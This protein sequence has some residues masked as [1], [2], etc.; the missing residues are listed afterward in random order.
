MV[1]ALGNVPDGKYNDMTAADRERSCPKPTPSPTKSPTIIA[2]GEITTTKS[3]TAPLG[4]SS[5][6]VGPSWEGTSV[7][8]EVDQDATE[9]TS[10]LADLCPSAVVVTPEDLVTMNVVTPYEYTFI[11][12]S[13]ADT[14][15]IVTEMESTLH[16][17][18]MELFC[19]EVGNGD[20]ARR[21]LQD[22]IIDYHGFRSN[23][24]DVINTVGCDASVIVPDG[25]TCYLVSGGVVAIVPSD[26]D[27]SV[28]MTDVG[29]FA[30]KVMSNPSNYEAF[31]ITEVAFTPLT[32][33]SNNENPFVGD[34]GSS[35]KDVVNVDGAQQSNDAAASNG[36]GGGLSQTGV[37]IVA[38]LCSVL[39]II[40]VALLAMHMRKKHKEADGSE[41]FGECYYLLILTEV[42]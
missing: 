31:G 15:L 11:A 3:P 41:L 14:T 12:D 22:V 32:S 18:L 28:V 42:V 19:P 27:S 10:R 13:T 34:D 25:Q 30:N 16:R 20:S 17:S 39:A 8:E 36:S 37:I 1:Y 5:V 7:P 9:S 29:N 38:V 2:P 21:M 4:A 23:P 24:T 40:L 35:D 6:T 33:D 26:T